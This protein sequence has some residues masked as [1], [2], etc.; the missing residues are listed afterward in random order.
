MVV[1]SARAPAALRHRFIGSAYLQLAVVALA[2]VIGPPLVPFIIS[3]PTV[4]G[5]DST[6]N[7]QLASLMAAAAAVIGVRRVS[8]YPGT[9]GFAAILPAFLTTY[10]FAASVLLV[11][12]FAYS[13]VVLAGGLALSIVVMFVL[14][15]L[16][17]RRAP[18]RFFIVPGS[19]T[20][21]VADTPRI[22]W[23]RLA[24]PVLPPDAEAAIVADLTLDHAPEWERMLAAAALSG[25]AVYHTK[26][27]RESLTGRVQIDHLSENNL[28]SLVPN[29]AYF[30]AKR[31]VDVLASAILLPLLVVP[32]L[33]VA[34]AIR[35]GSPGPAF[36]RQT[37]VG[38]R[39]ERFT[40]LKFR[41]MRHI[42]PDGVRDPVTRTDDDRI[43]GIGRLLRRLRVDEL[44]Q[45]INVLKGEMSLI[46]PR[47]EA[48]ELSAW[49]ER[50]LPF[51]V[52]RHIVRPGIT[53][54]AQINQGHV[55]D[56]AAVHVKLQYD[57]YYI[58]NFSAWMDMLITM[59]TVVVMLTGMGAK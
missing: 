40:V 24:E 49:Y 57:F 12:R 26:Q 44:P 34:I 37:R 10:G 46:G 20:G 23:I 13:G 21:I 53:G 29:L 5:L 9:R 1:R 17:L 42:A 35:L 48:I 38:Y 45:L 56:L 14:S 39:G 47:P 18:L 28:G 36:F 55:A 59:R 31:L 51:Y 15:Y 3:G 43:T 19:E 25:R 41:T 2:A 58:R 16:A 30:E 22:S 11:G 50:E 33:V 7:A 8:A 6:Y 27:L 54:W 4:V 32:M 52:Y